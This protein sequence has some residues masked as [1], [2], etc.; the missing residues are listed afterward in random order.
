[1]PRLH[2]SHPSTLFLTL[3]AGTAAIA[4]CLAAPGQSGPDRDDWPSVGRDAGGTRYSP[5]R[6]IDRKN[7]GRL[8][9]AWT[10]HTGDLPRD[11][12]STIE[13]TPIVLDGTLYLTIV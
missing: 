9:V 13:C 12:P 11:R 5:L 6:Q 7:V 8:Q 10:Y 3:A 2:P 1:M 4:L